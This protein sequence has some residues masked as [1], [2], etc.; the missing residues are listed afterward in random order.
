[1]DDA[2]VAAGLVQRDRVLLLDDDDTPFG[3]PAGNV[4][5]GCQ[6]DDPRSDDNDVRVVGKVSLAHVTFCGQTD[7]RSGSS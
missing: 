4:D 2:A 1:V 6:T 7:N 3:E 5:R